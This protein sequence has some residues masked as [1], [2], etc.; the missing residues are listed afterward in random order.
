MNWKKWI[1]SLGLVACLLFETIPTMAF[2]A[3]QQDVVKNQDSNSVPFTDVDM[4][5]W[6]GDSVQYVYKHQLMS[7]TSKTTFEPNIVMSR[8]MVAQILYNQSDRPEITDGDSG[9]ID[10]VEADWF[11]TAVKWARENGYALGVGSNRFDPNAAVTREQFAQFLYNYIG[12]PEVQ[13][14]DLRKF[15]DGNSISW[16]K[17]AMTWAVQ[18]KLINGV[19]KGDGIE[20]RPWLMPHDNATRAQAATI[21]KSFYMKVIKPE[22]TVASGECGENVSW[23][24]DKSGVLYIR[25]MGDMAENHRLDS[26]P[27]NEIASKVKTVLI[28]EGVTSICDQAFFDFTNMTNITISNQVVSI[29]RYAFSNC[30]SL[31]SIEIP[32]SVTKIDEGAFSECI[33]L[34]SVTMPEK[35]T[36][37]S[38]KE[39]SGCKSLKNFEIS[40][41]ITAI[42]GCAFFDCSSLENITIPNSV[43]AIGRC[44]FSRCSSLENITIPDSVTEL[45]GT[46]FGCE[47]LSNV[48]LPSNLINIGEDTFSVCS[49]LESMKIPNSVTSLGAAAFNECTSLKKIE[50]P[51]SVEEIGRYAF[52]YDD[53]LSD[54][55]GRLPMNLTDLEEGVFYGCHNL[56]SIELPRN[57]TKIGEETF[58]HSGLTSV[59]IPASVTEIGKSAFIEC[60][61]LSYVKISN[62]VSGLGEWMFYGCSRLTGIEIPDSVTRIGNEAFYDCNALSDVY[63]KGTEEQWKA[64]IIGKSNQPLNSATIHYNS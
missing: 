43:T 33:N 8:A 62:G 21:L 17:N 7:G 24:L 53:N 64:I 27:W 16:S 41:S 30:Q 18:N 19:E 57:I 29:G 9:F 34:S 13:G 38:A 54:I 4:N 1:S 51:D 23:A 46:F 60:P 3:E 48:Q 10:V 5:S 42:G 2:A 14:D 47:K 20:I 6:Y 31:K 59:E 49:S 15:P 56:T 58:G 39:F 63:Y 52:A 22:N 28:E 11:Y 26:S 40:N 44:A 61:D 55:G 50:I 36:T 35:I 37:I 12:Q 32:D 45:D 25:G